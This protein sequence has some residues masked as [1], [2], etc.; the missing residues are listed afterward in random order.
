[1][2]FGDIMGEMLVLFGVFDVCFMGGSL[3]GKKVGGYNLFEFVVLVKFIVIGFSFY[4]FIDIIYVFINVYVC[5]I[6]D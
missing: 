2:Y 6:V 3:V 4:N 1:M 5:V